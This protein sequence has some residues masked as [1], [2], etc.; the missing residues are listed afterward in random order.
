MYTTASWKYF[1]NLELRTISR[2]HNNQQVDGGH[3]EAEEEAGI[4]KIAESVVK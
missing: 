2:W 1:I 4:C 3:Y